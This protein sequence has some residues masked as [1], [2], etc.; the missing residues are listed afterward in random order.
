MFRYLWWWPADRRIQERAVLLWN[1]SSSKQQSNKV[2]YIIAS[3]VYFKVCSFL[4]RLQ[5][6]KDTTCSELQTFILDQFI[7]LKILNLNLYT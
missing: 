6:Q 7:C 2:Y 5:I 3:D 4:L 1:G